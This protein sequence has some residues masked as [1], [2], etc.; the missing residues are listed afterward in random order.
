MQQIT[1]MWTA[2]DMRRRIVVVGATLV[3]ALAILGLARMAARPGMSLLYA[4]LESAAAG[5]VV[6]ALEQRGVAYQVRGDAIYVD[7]S[8]RDSLRMTLAGEGLPRNTTQGYELLDKLSGFGTTAQM[9]DAAYWRA[10]EGEL[11]RTIVSHP[12]IRA[13]RVHI[14]TTGN[15]P[16][17]RDVQP[18]AS[19]TITASSGAVT[20]RQARALRYLV[21]SAV[22]GLDPAQVAV[23]DADGVLVGDGN[24]PPGKAGD[25]RAEVIRNKVLRLLEAHVGRGNAVVEVSV[26]TRTSR[27]TVHERR[28]DPEGRVTISSDTR[29]TSDSSTG[30]DSAVT[31]ASNLPNGN[32]QGGGTQSTSEKTETRNR[33]NYEVSQVD[34]EI[35]HEPGALSRL[36]V[37]VL[38]G[39]ITGADAGGAKAFAPRSEQELATLR[40]LVAGAV[41]FDEKRG[42]VITIRSL[43]LDA[44]TPEGTTATAG[45][46]DRLGLDLMSLIQAGVLA[47]VTLVLGLFVLRPLFLRP[48]QAARPQLSPP[49]EPTTESGPV[50]SAA[51]TGEI[52][53]DGSAETGMTLSANAPRSGQAQLSA[54]NTQDPVERL[55][56]LIG[57]R[58]EETVEILRNWLEGE[59]E[60]A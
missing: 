28:F 13:A 57:Q 53:Y 8:Q 41:G 27:E 49:A 23:I 25:D 35:V 10:K 1:A 45:L 47:L 58:Q 29:E 56:D 36:S 34:R 5:E 39:G 44:S 38:V 21:A 26:D 60:T 15:N 31:V 9:F 40:D 14:A 48:P 4:G 12:A 11:A 46:M 19:V 2:W 7:A 55:R 42:D 43:Q 51:L 3:L 32:A 22:P 54:P 33:V 52:A 30:R 20:P 59:E 16:F 17:Q 24:A 6:S 37:A 18:T 50:P